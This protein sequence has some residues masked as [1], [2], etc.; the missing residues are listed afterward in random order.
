MEVGLSLLAH[1]CMP[2]KFWDENFSTAA[3]LINRL[4]SH[5]I[6]FDSPFEKL[7]HTKPDYT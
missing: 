5:V 7:F 3:Y 6:E 2:L 1:A 4:P